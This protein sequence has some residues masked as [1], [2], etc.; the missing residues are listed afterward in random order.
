MYIKHFF[1]YSIFKKYPF[2]ILDIPNMHLLASRVN[3]LR[4]ILFSNCNSSTKYL[5][6]SWSFN[7]VDI[8]LLIYVSK[9]VKQYYWHTAKER[10]IF[11]LC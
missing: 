3:I 8:L 7:D 11:Q 2:N 9:S 1:F 6:L 10:N 5:T 4:N